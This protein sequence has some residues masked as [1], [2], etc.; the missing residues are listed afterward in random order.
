VAGK[1]S[2]GREPARLAVPGEAQPA[3]DRWTLLWRAKVWIAL[4]TVV[5]GA[6]AYS[7]SNRITPSY[8]ASS[9]VE[10]SAHP[11]TGIS[12]Q[13]IATA[14][15]ELAAQLA[16]LTR[17]APV[18]ELAAQSLHDSAGA[19]GQ[20]VVAAVLANQN[21]IQ[22]TAQNTTPKTTQARATAMAEALQGYV[23][24]QGASATGTAP[25]APTNTQL[26]AIDTQLA[27]AQADAAKAEAAAATSYPGTVGIAVAAQKAAFVQ[28]LQLQRNTV[29]MQVEAAYANATPTVQVL[30]G[31]S[32]AVKVQPRPT[33][34]AGVTL[35]LAALLAGQISVFVGS[36]RH[37]KPRAISKRGQ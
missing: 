23:S 12:P 24:A 34:Y 3:P 29:A 6:G 28:Q 17:T 2:P 33:L 30:G 13:D 25:P 1:P 5:A 31:A 21:L 16:Q 7:A 11:Q 15:N 37:L 18:V 19:V 26:A 22:I 36:R 10:V 14:S 32:A 9:L 35:V 20:H 8:Q 27:A 4:A